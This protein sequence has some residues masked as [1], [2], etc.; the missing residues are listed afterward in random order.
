[1]SALTSHS[2]ALQTFASARLLELDGVSRRC[3][4]LP[5]RCVLVGRGKSHGWVVKDN[6]G[7]LGG[8]FRSAGAAL[9]FAKKEAVFLHCAVVVDSG[10]VELDWRSP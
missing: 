5:A 4:A 1:M 3:A 10:R 9:R 2:P 6:W 8:I 7:K